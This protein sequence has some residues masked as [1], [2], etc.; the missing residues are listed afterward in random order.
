M[1]KPSESGHFCT[2]LILYN[3][4]KASSNKKVKT[5]KKYYGFEHSPTSVLSVTS[6]WWLSIKKNT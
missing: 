1:Q 3:K 2:F 6:F 4:L 5:K